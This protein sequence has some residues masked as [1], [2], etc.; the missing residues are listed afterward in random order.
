LLRG[1]TA[2]DTCGACH[3]GQVG[4]SQG[5]NVL[6]ELN[7]ISR[8][9]NPN[10]TPVVPTK[11]RAAEVNTSSVD[12]SSCHEPHTMQSGI[13]SAP[14]I[15]PKLGE[16]S[17][18]NASGAPIPKANYNYEVCFKC[19]AE[20]STV[21][22]RVSR[23]IEQTNT[24]LEFAPSAVSF[25][26]IEVQGKNQDVPSL[27]PGLTTGSMIYC[28]DCHASETSTASG[29]GTGP[30]GPH[31]SNIA[32]LLNA[33]YEMTDGS[34]ESAVAYA[35]CYRCHERSSI[36]SDQSFVGH[37]RHIVN[38]RTPCSVCHDAHGISSAQGNATN[39]GKL[40]NFDVGVV[41]PDPATG[42]LEYRST[43]PRMG[44]CYLSCHGVAH[45]PKTYPGGALAPA[46]PVQVRQPLDVQRRATPQ[47]NAKPKPRGLK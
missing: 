43:G 40:I 32:P 13:A 26:P 5:A 12:C 37:Q 21:R 18:E 4:P 17:G 2:T 24:R 15:S 16:V 35:L 1:V 47:P 11:L 10:P 38:D 45:S 44:A 33:G 46:N 39:N 27:T 20:N 42:R 7:K 29:G 25:H 41:Q 9:G 3:G 30:N 23:Q 19:H 6:A 22:Q 8:H 34:G 28:V 14:L 31:G 36:L